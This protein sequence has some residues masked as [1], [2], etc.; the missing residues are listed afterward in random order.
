VERLDR[1][2]W[3]ARVSVPLPPE[4]LS[5]C[6]FSRT[7]TTILSLELSVTSGVAS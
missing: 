5:Y 7:I 4:K 6:P 3:N 1:C 2:E